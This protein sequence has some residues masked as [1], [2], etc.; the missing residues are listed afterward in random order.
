[1]SSFSPS[2]SPSPSLTACLDDSNLIFKLSFSGFTFSITYE[3]SYIWN[4]NS[5]T[6]LFNG[7]HCEL[8]ICEAEGNIELLSDGNTVTFKILKRGDVRGDIEIQVPFTSC[9]QA[10]ETCRQAKVWDV[11]SVLQEDLDFETLELKTLELQ[12]LKDD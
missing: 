7:E 12:T 2:S 9:H 11:D 1:M 10:F 4:E 6:K 8:T 5:W 3:M